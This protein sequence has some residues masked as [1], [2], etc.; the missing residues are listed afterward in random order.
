[1]VG[2]LDI[3]NKPDPENSFQNFPVE[4]RFN[5]LSSFDWPDLSRPPYDYRLIPTSEFEAEVRKDC[6]PR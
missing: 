4:F 2:S 6:G 1:M 3:R 5:Q